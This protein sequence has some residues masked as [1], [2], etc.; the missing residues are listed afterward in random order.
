M[1]DIDFV[2]RSFGGHVQSACG[3]KGIFIQNDSQ[4]IVEFYRVFGKI[5]TVYFFMPMTRLDIQTGREIEVDEYMI[6]ERCREN[7]DLQYRQIR[8]KLGF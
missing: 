1:T 6:C 5:D 7:F 3:L 4:N 8:R 2:M